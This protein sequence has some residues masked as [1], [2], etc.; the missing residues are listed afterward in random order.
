MAIVGYG[1]D[2]GGFK[3]D[4]DRRHHDSNLE[5]NL[6]VYKM[7]GCVSILAQESSMVLVVMGMQQVIVQW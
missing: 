7:F 4:A 2:N 5:I 6:L 1:T 3:T